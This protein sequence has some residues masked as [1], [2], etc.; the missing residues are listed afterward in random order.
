[1]PRRNCTT[2]LRLS[3]ARFAKSYSLA[4]VRASMPKLIEPSQLARRRYEECDV[5]EKLLGHRE[6]RIGKIASHSPIDFVGIGTGDPE[7][8]FMPFPY[9]SQRLPIR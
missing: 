3:A 7:A 4:I 2:P 1:M 6:L 5:G 9:E 8:H